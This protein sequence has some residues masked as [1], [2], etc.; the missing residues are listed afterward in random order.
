MAVWPLPRIDF[1]E[2]SSIEET[3]PVALLTTDDTWTVLGSQLNLPVIIQAEPARQT[4]EL[5]GYLADNLPR[6]VQAI[7]VI[8]QGAPL[9]AG[10]VVAARNRV[11]LVV[12]PTA[13]DSDA[14]IS[15]V[16]RIDEAS[17]DES[18]VVWQETGPATDV[19][20]DWGIIQA[21]PPDQRGAG[22][23]DV[24]SVV[25]GLLD[26][27]YAAQKGR[28]LSGQRFSPWA[29]GVAAG[30]ASQAI[31]SA[32]AIGQGNRDALRTLLDLMMT[33]VQVSNQL[34]HT[35]ACQGGEHYL[36]QIL[37][38]VAPETPHSALVGPCLLLVSTLH[39]QPPTA[40]REAMEH[41][42][43]RLDQVRPTDVRLILDAL[44]DHLDAY[45]FPYSILNDIDPDSE[46]VAQALD[47]AGLAIQPDTWALPP[48]AGELLTVDAPDKAEAGLDETRPADQPDDD[49]DDEQMLDGWILD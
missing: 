46:T 28:N 43:V 14:A 26:W 24:L 16:A 25:T 27:R 18:R 21:A 11:P 47:A 37:A 39:G 30:L 48:E 10:K 7:Y 42:G 4:R 15:P 35:R 2:L 9:M 13:L 6:Q 41:A 38:S 40:L 20:I 17:E 45:D 31:K 8:G 34:G 22:I 33:A 19:I 49:P 23:V 12:I 1:R 36:A 44:P 29:A 5:F 3:R 32:A